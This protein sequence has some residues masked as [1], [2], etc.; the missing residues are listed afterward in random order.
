M[1]PLVH[2][3]FEHTSPRAHFAPHAPQFAA[4]DVTFTHEPLHRS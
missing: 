3:P 1:Q 2:V 4:D